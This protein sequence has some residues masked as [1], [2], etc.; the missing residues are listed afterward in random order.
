LPVEAVFLG[1]QICSL[2]APRFPLTPAGK[3]FDATMQQVEQV[4]G[5]CLGL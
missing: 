2:D 4:V 5:Y 3:I 1:F